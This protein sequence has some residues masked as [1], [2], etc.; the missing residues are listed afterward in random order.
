MGSAPRFQLILA[1]EGTTATLVGPMAAELEGYA[2][3]V[4]VDGTREGP[5]PGMGLVIT[6]KT[7]RLAGD[8][9]HAP[10]VGTIRARGAMYFIET[11]DKR[12]LRVVAADTATLASA[13]GHLVWLTATW[14]HGALQ[15]IRLGPLGRP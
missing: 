11:R 8:G 14:S 13:V 5:L 6:V 9:K 7:Y 12:R 3:R 15:L 10:I 4:C 1:G 2:G